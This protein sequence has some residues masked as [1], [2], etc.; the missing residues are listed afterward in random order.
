MNIIKKTVDLTLN[1]EEFI[2]CFDMKSIMTYKELSG[3]SFL[4]GMQKLA[5]LDEE[6]ILNF[7]ASTIRKDEKSKPLGK[8]L[9]NEYD[10]LGLLIN[11]T[12]PIMKLIADSMPQDK[13]GNTAKK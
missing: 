11:Y 12:E 9:L 8:K 1:E 5:N 6:V 7:M 13:G 3:E 4:Q 10:V 2:A